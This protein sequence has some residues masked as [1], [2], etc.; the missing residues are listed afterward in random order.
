[1]NY[2]DCTR[3][4]FLKCS[5]NSR[6]HVVLLLSLNL[7]LGFAFVRKETRATYPFRPPDIKRERLTDHEAKQMTMG[8]SISTVTFIRGNVADATSR[9]VLGLNV[10]LW[11]IPGLQD[12]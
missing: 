9:F 7:G 3:T 6:L 1:M 5:F 12:V 10:L 4:F 8:P 11:L 2:R